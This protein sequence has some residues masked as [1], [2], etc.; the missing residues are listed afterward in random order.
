[1]AS[2]LTTFNFN[3][4]SKEAGITDSYFIPKPVEPDIPEDV[5]EIEASKSEKKSD[6]LKKKEKST[7]KSSKSSK[8]ESVK[9]S[10][11]KIGLEQVSDISSL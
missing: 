8:K 2:P 7:S 9:A 11:L 6:K 5:A 3:E 10:Q 1:M 4:A